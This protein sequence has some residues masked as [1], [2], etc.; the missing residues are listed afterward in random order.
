MLSY[1]QR[2][3]AAA[4]LRAYADDFNALAADPRRAMSRPGAR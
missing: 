3:R 2:S 1:E 4:R